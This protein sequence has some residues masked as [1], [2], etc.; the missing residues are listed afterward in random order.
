MGAARNDADCTG[1]AVVYLAVPQD[2]AGVSRTPI[3]RSPCRCPGSQS[4]SALWLTSPGSVRLPCAASSQA[5]ITPGCLS[6]LNASLCQKARWERGKPPPLGD[7]ARETR[8]QACLSP[9]WRVPAGIPY[10]PTRLIRS[11]GT[12]LPEVRFA[13]GVTPLSVTCRRWYAAPG[14]GTLQSCWGA[15][16]RQ[17]ALAKCVRI[18]PSLPSRGGNRC[19][20]RSRRF[21]AAFL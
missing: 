13:G 9:G 4:I 18:A 12:W 7:L 8:A 10:I 20:F 19:D 11:R 2:P 16:R 15:T 5:G 17:G 3:S 21:S 1:S 14:C 6:N